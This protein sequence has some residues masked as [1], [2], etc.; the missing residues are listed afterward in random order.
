M[1][2]I[3]EKRVLFKNIVSSLEKMFFLNAFLLEKGLFSGTSSQRF[4]EKGLFF[5]SENISERGNFLI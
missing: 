3:L 2:S 5:S 1:S 4:K